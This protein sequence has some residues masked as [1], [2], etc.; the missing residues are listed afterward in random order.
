MQNATHD[1]LSDVQ[2]NLIKSF[3]YLHNEQELKEIDSLINFYLEQKLDEAIIKAESDRNYS[4]DIYERW[5]N[6]PKNAG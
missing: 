4:A 2:L 1:K 3:R 5:L 6:I